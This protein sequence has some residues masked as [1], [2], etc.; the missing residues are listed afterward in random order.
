[1]LN[2]AHSRLTYNK[3]LTN[4]S[5]KVHFTIKFIIPLAH[6]QAMM[7]IHMHCTYQVQVL[8]ADTFNLNCKLSNLSEIYI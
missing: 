4:F 1:M 7:H 8:V 2:S 5:N 6:V 3:F